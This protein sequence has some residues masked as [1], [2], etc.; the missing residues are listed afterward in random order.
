[1]TLFGK[2]VVA[3]IISQANVIL[4]LV[5]HLNQID[6]CPYKRSKYGHRYMRRMP[7]E[8]KGTD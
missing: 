6:Q 1:M 2:R 5:G 8:N 4:K 7:G 3:D